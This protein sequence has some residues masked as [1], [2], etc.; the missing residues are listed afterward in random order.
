MGVVSSSPAGL[1]LLLNAPLQCWSDIP[2]EK[3]LERPIEITPTKPSESTETE[4]A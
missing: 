3:L 4:V 2:Q 1:K